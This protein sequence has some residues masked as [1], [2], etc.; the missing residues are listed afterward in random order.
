MYG[1]Y[2]LNLLIDTDCGVDDAGAIMM[3][4]AD[5]NTNVLGLSTVAGNVPLKQVTTNVLQLLSYFG[6]QDIPVYPGAYK[7]LVE[8]ARDASGVHGSNGLGGVSLPPAKRAAEDTRAPEGLYTLARKH[9]GCSIAA[10]GPLTN[11]ACALVLYPDLPDLVEHLYIMGGAIDRGN[12][13]R[14]AEFNIA[15]DPEAAETVFTSGIPFTLLPWDVC[16]A[17]IFTEE[18]LLSLGLEG[19][20]AGKFFLDTAQAPLNFFQA[21]SGRRAMAMADELAMACCLSPG[22]ITGRMRTDIHVELGKNALR[23][24]TVTMAGSSVTVVTTVN[25]EKFIDSLSAINGL[26]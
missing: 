17:N 11:L 12:V 9:P 15:A 3:A 6:R 18:E 20:K 23:G 13:T 7:P 1:G 2:R 14:Y 24:A 4:L 5:K 19:S 25:R 21:L 8:P 10:L 22:V 16:L 26:S